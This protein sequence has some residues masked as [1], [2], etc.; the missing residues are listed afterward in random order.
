[1]SLMLSLQMFAQESLNFESTKFQDILSKAKKEKK[2][3]FLDAFAAWCGPCKLMEKN[4]FPLENVKSYYNTNFINARFDM[5]KG[6]GREIAAK[7]GIR[8][9]PTFL[10][11]NGDGEV[12]HKAFGYMDE[13]EFLA[14]AV[15]ANNPENRTSSL[16]ERF[17]SGEKDP[18]FLVNMMRLY[19]ETDYALAKKASERYFAGR[20]EA[21]TKDDV[22]LLLYFIKSPQD[23]NFKIFTARKQE[24]L[25]FLP[26]DIY[27]QFDNNIKLSDIMENSLDM[28]SRLIKDDY[29]LKN[30]TPLVGQEEA[31][32][33]L[34]RLKVNF[35]PT[36]G[37]YD[38][39][40]KAALAYYANPDKF[41][42]EEL[43]KAAWIFIENVSSLSS[44]KKAQEW[45][46]KSVMR[47]ESAENTYIL[48]KLY[49]KTGNKESAKMYAEMSRNLA[50]Q[51]GKD[52]SLASRLLEDLK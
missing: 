15:Q 51:Q 11:L 50:Q 28:N 12:V 17:D 4:I 8:S 37:K 26:A 36:V 47:S 30:A 6:E 46:E 22:G 34:H 5:E 44:L 25:Q 41:A 19:S 21:F 23:P 52:S 40:E 39:Y 29:F 7:Y 16:K 33:M 32:K 20:K 48:A 43:L 18:D 42:P 10:Y 49:S 14:A 45:A 3:V 9:Y 13:N 31:L 38:E 35:Y 1:M 27:T 2:L 24:I